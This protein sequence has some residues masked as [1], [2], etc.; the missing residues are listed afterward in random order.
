MKRATLDL[1]VGP[2][3]AR[4]FFGIRAPFLIPDEELD[5]A[6]K[7]ELRSQFYTDLGETFM[8]GTPLMQ[9]PLGLSAYLPAVIDPPE[10]S[11]LPDEV[12]IIVYASLEVYNRFRS[13]SLSRRMYTK[14]HVAV[15]DMERSAA[16]F[17]KSAAQPAVR[18]FEGGEGHYGYMSEA[19]TD[20]QAGYTRIVLI[21]ADS[22]SDGFRDAALAAVAGAGEAAQSA[23][24]DQVLVGATPS[25]AA[26][27]IHSDSE[28]GD[29]AQALRLIPDGAS[30]L[31]DLPAEPAPV[32]GDA[33]PGVKVTGTCAFTFRFSRQRE[34][35]DDRN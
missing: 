19:A 12:A 11:G 29:P 2:Q 14:S 35:F 8:P 5:N 34:F 31:R 6:K 20:W 9:A 21:T 25:F 33:E 13:T 7:E 26:L 4:I 17:P 18:P 23:G 16:Q 15:F 24:I 22:P 32:I 27:W 10:G 28:V 3:A 1:P 30:V